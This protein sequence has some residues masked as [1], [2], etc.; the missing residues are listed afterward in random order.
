MSR[1]GCGALSTR[2]DL[3]AVYVRTQRERHVEDVSTNLFMEREVH[4]LVA[5]FIVVHEGKRSSVEFLG[6]A[7]VFSRAIS[8]MPVWRADTRSRSSTHF[9]CR[10]ERASVRRFEEGKASVYALIA[11][12][13]LMSFRD[14][15]FAACASRENTEA[16]T[17]ARS[18]RE[19]AETKAAA[20]RPTTEKRGCLSLSVLA[21]EDGIRH[22][23]AAAP[24]LTDARMDEYW[25]IVSLTPLF[26][27]VFNL[28]VGSTGRPQQVA[29]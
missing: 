17:S 20:G 7:P 25:S 13:Q 2:L 11:K 6:I 22:A 12:D 8:D 23:I 9:A 29:F 27:K 5:F 28:R 21:A 18:Q 14:L 16:E 4:Q 24:S 15:S 3:E 19:T 26:C 10:R 1:C